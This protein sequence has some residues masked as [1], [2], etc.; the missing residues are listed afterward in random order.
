MA[1]LV[2]LER[3][4][5]SL[6]VAELV[7][8]GA[9]EPL[10]ELNQAESYFLFCLKMQQLVEESSRRHLACPN[11]VHDLMILIASQTKASKKNS[12][13]SSGYFDMDIVSMGS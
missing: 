3:S 8:A 10:N 1:F 6:N 2:T 9:F 13:E 4:A 12:N 7:C 5:P 11:Q